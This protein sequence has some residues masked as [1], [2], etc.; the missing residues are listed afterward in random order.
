M[1]DGSPVDSFGCTVRQ[2]HLSLREAGVVIDEIKKSPK[3]TGYNKVEWTRTKTTFVAEGRG[4][5]L[6][7]VCLVDD[8]HR[9][10]AEIAVVYVLPQYRRAGI[11]RSLIEAA[12]ASI[13]QRGKNTLIFFSEPVV[14][15]IVVD[16]GFKTSSGLT[17]LSEELKQERWI[18]RH[19]YPVRWLSNPFRIKEIIRKK[20]VFDMDL[21]F[22]CAASL[23]VRNAP[24]I[25]LA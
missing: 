7:G 18:L 14:R 22:E 13:R 4:G 24:R 23:A 17:R 1:M 9:T 11:G 3:I 6:S 19:Y 15:N 21:N 10:W 25:V 12:H 2:R 16:L 8:F 20:F 5:E